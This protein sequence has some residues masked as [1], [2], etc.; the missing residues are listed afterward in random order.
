M[1]RFGK[2]LSAA[3]GVMAIAAFMGAA[4]GFGTQLT[5]W[6]ETG[7]WK[8]WQSLADAWPALGSKVAAMK[9]LDGQRLALWLMAQPM[10]LIYVVSG[11][12]CLLISFLLKGERRET[13]A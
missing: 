7:T 6:V 9:W 3:F 12:V 4:L 1:S 5:H 11:F 2:L 10:T 8:V 13:P